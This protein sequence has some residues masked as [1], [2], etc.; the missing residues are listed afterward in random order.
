MRLSCSRR[1]ALSVLGVDCDP[2]WPACNV[3]ELLKFIGEATLLEGTS[4]PPVVS[5]WASSCSS[6]SSSTTA[7]DSSVFCSSALEP[8]AV[9]DFTS[10][11]RGVFR[12]FG[13]SVDSGKAE[14]YKEVFPLSGFV[15]R[16]YLNCRR[17]DG[18][19]QRS[20]V[21]LGLDASSA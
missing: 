17:W 11:R 14:K 16:L 2:G 6:C 3:G 12:R 7:D 4:V 10:D 9:W 8:T 19:G 15:L 18:R 1:S 13:F 20:M 5:L 21:A